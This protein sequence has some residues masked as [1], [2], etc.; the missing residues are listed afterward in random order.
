MSNESPLFAKT[1]D[2]LAYL[3]PAVD[4]FPRS[5]RAVLGR[6]IQ[7][8]G[9]GML[10]LLLS[11]RKC[12]V[13]Q[14]GSLLRQADLELDKLRYAVRLCHGISL[15]SLKQYRYASGLL[16]EVGRLLGTWIKRYNSE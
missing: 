14:R 5:H 7:E 8:T 9:L 12:P 13:E 2:L 15:L 3:F 11:A 1:Y 16:A 6:R 10:D 4:K